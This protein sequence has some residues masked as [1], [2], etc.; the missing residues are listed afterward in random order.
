MT[1]NQ[2]CFAVVLMHPFHKTIYTIVC[3]VSRG[4][5]T[6]PSFNWFL[7]HHVYRLA[8]SSL[9]FPFFVDISF[10]PFQNIQGSEIRNGNFLWLISGPGIFLGCVGSPKDFWGF[11]VLPS[12]DHPRHL[13]SG[14]PPW[15]CDPLNLLNSTSLFSKTSATVIDGSEKCNRWLKSWTSGFACYWKTQ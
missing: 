3:K 9:K 1:Y 13:K 11:L 7:I 12:F 5:S 10:H 2:T 14:V 8:L 6:K 4:V 15:E